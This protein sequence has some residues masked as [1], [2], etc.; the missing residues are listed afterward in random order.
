MEQTL[1]TLHR[2]GD[3]LSVLCRIMLGVTSLALCFAV[4]GQFILRWFHMSMP[5][6]S[7]F[8]CYIFCMDDNAWQ[9]PCKQTSY[10]Y[11][12]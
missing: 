5:W 9:C 4:I 3:G 8:A 1:K 12:R 7:E 2:I 6:A 10:A 11:R